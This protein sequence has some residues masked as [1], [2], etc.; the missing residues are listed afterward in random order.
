[1]EFKLLL[2]YYP[3]I[4][5]ILGFALQ[6]IL[7]KRHLRFFIPLGSFLLTPVILLFHLKASLSME[8]FFMYPILYA[9]LSF[10]GSLLALILLALDPRKKM[11]P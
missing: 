3:L 5:F 6:L 11:S 8:L 7:F 1:M 4:F 10:K 9:A 2:I